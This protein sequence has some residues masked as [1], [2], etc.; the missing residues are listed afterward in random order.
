MRVQRYRF[1]GVQISTPYNVD[2]VDP[3]G[4]RFRRTT[5]D[6]VAFVGQVSEHISS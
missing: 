4:A 2:Q 3:A 5:H 1:R 6:D